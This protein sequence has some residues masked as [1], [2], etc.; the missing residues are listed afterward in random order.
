MKRKYFIFPEGGA[1]TAVKTLKHEKEALA[2][3]N[4][5]K[6]LYTYG[7]MRLQMRDED[8]TSFRWDEYKG[9]WIPE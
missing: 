1:D 6:N 5:V 3:V 4:D 9:E 7:C 8:G 2:F